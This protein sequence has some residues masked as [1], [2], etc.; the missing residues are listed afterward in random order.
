MSGVLFCEGKY[1]IQVLSDVVNGLEGWTIQP[2][3]GVRGTKGFIKGYEKA[4]NVLKGHNIGFR[5][6]DF[7]FP[8][9]EKLF[10]DGSIVVSARICME[11]YLLHPEGVY[12]Y[13]KSKQTKISFKEVEE[14]FFETYEELK[15]Y[16]A[17]RHALGKTRKSVRLG[18]RWT[19]EIGKL[20]TNLSEN[21]CL[22]EAKKLIET[23]QKKQ[24]TIT[25]SQFETNYQLF[26]HTFDSSF[27]KS[28]QP[29]IWFHG[30]DLMTQLIPKIQQ[31]YANFGRDR[32][33]SFALDVFDYA[34]FPDLVKLH[35]HL[36]S[37]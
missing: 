35:H 23:F 24:E 18:T 29:L 32:Y 14:L 34:Q 3:G 15:Y 30:K 7:D 9:D 12:Q 10:L 17:T 27:I 33:Y 22:E 13:L 2:T 20:P 1:D 37:L 8:I 16:Q 11:N 19:S 5:D 26:L 4:S 25:T 6:Q 36:K 31:H 21:F 28:R